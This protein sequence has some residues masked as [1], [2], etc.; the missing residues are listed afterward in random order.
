ME[1]SVKEV[2]TI[3]EVKIRSSFTNDR[4]IKVVPVTVNTIERVNQFQ[5]DEN[6]NKVLK[7][8]RQVPNV[9]LSDFT[10]LLALSPYLPLIK[11]SAV[12][13]TAAEDE[14][15]NTMYEDHLRCLGGAKLTLERVEIRD[16]EYTDEPELDKDGNPKV[17]ENED[18]VYKKALDDKGNPITKL[19]GYGETSYLKLELT[20]PALDEA[21]RLIREKVVVPIVEE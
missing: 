12:S 19:I 8:I 7:S 9:N 20:D 5:K 15:L 2:V 10:R 18:V 17:D 13:K 11:K 3:S 1:K 21:K 6:D 14:Q 16:Y 4:G